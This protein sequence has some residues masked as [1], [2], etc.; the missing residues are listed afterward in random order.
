MKRFEI[1][2]TIKAKTIEKASEKFATVLAANGYK[3]A[4]NEVFE[5]V[6]NGYFY[7]TNASGIDL[8]RNGRPLPPRTN[9]WSYYWAIE[10]IDNGKYYAWFIERT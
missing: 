10:E 1:D 4:A 5:T 2:R 7:C 3:W 8:I 9:D 6:S